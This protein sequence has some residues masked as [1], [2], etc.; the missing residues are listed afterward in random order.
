MKLAFVFVLILL[1]MLALGCGEEN[2]L[3]ESAMLPMPH[4]V[5]VDER[6]EVSPES[7]QTWEL[8]F[9]K[10]SKLHGEI[11]SDPEVNILLLS[12]REFEAYENREPFRIHSAASRMRT[13]AFTFTYA[14]PESGRYHFVVSN[15]GSVSTSK[16][17]SV[18]LTLTQ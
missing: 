2:V 8:L 1:V 10:D 3:T 6:I 15:V 12:P 4:T 7:Y 9:L 17:V 16:V 14:I 18:R 11:A 5:L 13:R